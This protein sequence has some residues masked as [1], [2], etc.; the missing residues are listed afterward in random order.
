MVNKELLDALFEAE[1]E[2]DEIESM[3]ELF[4]EAFDKIEDARNRVDKMQKA[5]VSLLTLPCREE[6]CKGPG[7]QGVVKPRGKKSSLRV[8]SPGSPLYFY[9]GE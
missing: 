6:Y 1:F 4:S 7:S 8:N 9:T 2:K 3:E 5:G